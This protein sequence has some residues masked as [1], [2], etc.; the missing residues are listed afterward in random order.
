MDGHFRGEQKYCIKVS[1][2]LD[3]YQFQ[4]NLKKLDGFSYGNEK[5]LPK[6]RS[7]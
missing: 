6:K 2:H 3:K 7:F 4:K 1:T 5:D